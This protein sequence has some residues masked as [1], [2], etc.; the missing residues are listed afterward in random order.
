M[1]G[2]ALSNTHQDNFMNT[3]SDYLDR[4]DI[5]I[6]QQRWDLALREVEKALAMEP[7]NT[8]GLCTRAF[9]LLRNNEIN[10]AEKVLRAALALDGAYSDAHAILGECLVEQ[11]RFDEAI[12]EVSEAVRLRPDDPGHF[13]SQSF[14]L[15]RTGRNEDALEAANNGLALNPINPDLLNNKARC[16]I[17]LGDYREAQ[18]TLKMAMEHDPENS[19]LHANQGVLWLTYGQRDQAVE[20]FSQALRIDPSNNLAQIG[21]LKAIECR[22]WFLQGC[23]ALEQ[24][25][26]PKGDAR[27]SP[28]SSPKL[29]LK[30]LIA[31]IVYAAVTG[32]LH[33]IAWPIWFL[34]STGIQFHFLRAATR[35]LFVIELYRDPIARQFLPKRE[36]AR[37]AVVAF[38]FV[39]FAVIL[40]CSIWI[41]SDLMFHL[42]W[43]PI[44]AIPY[45]AAIIQKRIVRSMAAISLLVFS[46]AV[47][48]L[49]TLFSGD[50]KPS[51][52]A[53]AVFW[54]LT[55]IS[56]LLSTICVQLVRKK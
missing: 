18:A 46:G 47:V 10:E 44:L 20:C 32:R 54:L 31:M 6:Q 27:Q 23:F 22:N 43:F 3:S 51:F 7:D 42:A 34:S 14:V 8:H 49:L 36:I 56:P 1:H 29:H 9:C 4:A 35:P 37:G 50:Q 17:A 41:G 55:I 2:A 40:A 26:R 24:W 33:W 30:V 38:L 48:G 52:N 15:G 11:G 28:G 16:F 12:L 13:C 5:L 21:L 19:N 53:L 25:G 39:A 45:T